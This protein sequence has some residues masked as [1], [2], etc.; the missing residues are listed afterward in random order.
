MVVKSK[1]IGE[2]PIRIDEFEGSNL[3]EEELEQGWEVGIGST[4]GVVFARGIGT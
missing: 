4:R 3:A 1:G 2:E